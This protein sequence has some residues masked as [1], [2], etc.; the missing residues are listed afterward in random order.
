[1]FQI[2]KRQL[3]DN[4]ARLVV[5]EIKSTPYIVGYSLSEWIKSENILVAEDEIG[6]LLGVC[7]IYDFHKDW[8]KIAALFVLNDFRGRG[9]G[10]ALFYRS[11]KDALERGKNVYMISANPIVIQMMKKSNFCLFKNIFNL[12]N[13]YTTYQL[14]FYIHHII[15]TM[16]LYRLKEIIRKKI[17]YNS[18]E[19]FVFGTLLHHS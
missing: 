13:S 18:S 12:Q 2:I 8:C 6:N 17:V 19:Y 16:N 7:L 11:V 4:E 1:M 5:K 3:T 10:K 14:Y 9:I 15:W